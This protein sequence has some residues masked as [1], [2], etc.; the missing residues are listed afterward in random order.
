MTSTPRIAALTAAGAPLPLPFARLVDALRRAGAEVVPVPVPRKPP[1]ERAEAPPKLSDLKAGL[2]ALA[3][4]VLSSLREDR[5]GQ[6]PDG[7]LVS[8]LRSIEGAV[9]GVVALDPAVA[10]LA[11]PAAA[12]V[13]PDAVR[14]AVDGDY[15]VDPEW[16]QVT[17]DDF[18]L[19]HPAA[20]RELSALRDGRIRARVGGPVVGGAEVEARTLDEQP[21]VVISFARVGSGEVDP[22]LF[23]LS[24][25]HPEKLTLLFLPSGRP[26]I[27]ELVRTRAA[28]YGLAGK[29]PKAGADLE[30]WVRGAA[31]LVG[32]PSPTEAAAAVHARVPQVLFST[33]RTLSGGDAFL[34]QH[35]AAVH[36]DNPILLSVRVE[37]LLPGGPDRAEA[38][39]ALEALASEG[40]ASAARAVLDAVAAGRPKPGE[41]PAAPVEEAGDAE[42]ED[43][44]GAAAQA[45]TPTGAMPLEL[46]RAYLSE[47]ILQHKDIER[48]L[49]RARTG[50]DTWGHRLQLARRAGDAELARQAQARVDGLSRI[51]GRLEQQDR[52]L[53]DLRDRFAGRNPLAAADREAAARYMNP[54]MAAMLDRMQGQDPEAFTRL[55]LND[56][57]TRLKDRMKG[58]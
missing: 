48:Q 12:Q 51:V 18:V 7:W 58:A 21:H 17:C 4:S 19:A 46:R 36:V 26:G 53:R 27:D 11:F 49:G 55:E 57:L 22:L 47:I 32:R 35:G 15:H 24:L 13:W 28:N 16:S 38:D 14:V 45:S 6:G 42:L 52:E 41:A 39:K 25:A 2:T 3:G 50:L 30:P 9:D 31:L 37:A 23:Q 5:A 54:E 1:P 10:Q 34:V 43:I 44:G 8:H 20:A 29:R 40:T 33:D 56:A